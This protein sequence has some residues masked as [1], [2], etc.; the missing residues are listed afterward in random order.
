MLHSILV[1]ALVLNSVQTIAIITLLKRC[2]ELAA[3]I[4]KLHQATNRT[5]TA[6]QGTL[7][8][9]NHGH[10]GPVPANPYEH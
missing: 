9:S 3:E 4:D 8:P 10:H 6:S 5:T 7:Q 2:G 1:F